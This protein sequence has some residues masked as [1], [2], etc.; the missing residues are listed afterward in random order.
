MSASDSSPSATIPPSAQLDSSILHVLM[1]TIPDKI[2]FKDLQS[3]IVRNNIAHAKS[4]GV[5]SPADCIGKTD[6]DFFSRQHADEALRDEQQILR[7]NQPMIGKVE[8]NT[9]LDGSF[10]WVSTTK[11]PWRDESGKLIGTFGLTRDITA[12]K[13]AEDK[14]NEERTLLRT[15]IDHLPSRIFVKDVDGRYVLNN[16]SHLA[17]LGAADQSAVT[18]RLPTDFYG[19]KRA[20]QAIEDDRKV[21]AGGPPV[22]D[23]EKSD[24]AE[25]KKS[26]WALTTK[27]PLKD[28]A[29]TITGI[30]GISHD[31][32]E[33][34]RTEQELQRRTA[35]METD[36][37][38]ACQ[39]QEAFFPREY[40]VF[41]RGV[42]P[43]A[44][45][46]Q[47]AHRYLPAATLGGDFFD[48][49]QLSDSQCGVLICD[50]MGHGVRAGLLT[51]LIRGL[52]EEFAPRVSEPA[53]V[54]AEINRGLLPIIR[55]TGQ[56][57]FATAFYGI[58]DTE[59]A[60]LHYANGGHPPPLIA[61]AGNSEVVALGWESPEPAAGLMEGFAYSSRKV[62][63]NSGDTLLAYTDGFM[64][65][66]NAAGEM[67]GKAR[68]SRFLNSHTA[69]TG[70]QIIAKLVDEIVVFAGRKDFDDDLCA[71]VIKST[72]QTCA[73]QPAYTYQI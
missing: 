2:Y 53:L 42:P 62:P 67:F 7:T 58:I 73:L 37:Q 38:M 68:L 3:R 51:A 57:V 21:L 29:G 19:G 43:E 23:E 72:G 61:H 44:S 46:L 6:Y 27:I 41:P 47:F 63:F 59:S 15:I 31:I 11:L 64:E 71:V 40:P 22:I 39:I 14:L 18:G 12:T 66:S 5:D 70:E 48:I 69:L 56:P 25:G 65:A 20:T 9:M 24:F 55:Q 28:P 4:L 60:T 35:E 10:T 13:L 1:D 16:R 45:Q 30:V 50:V 34:K 54:L 17:A 52:V 49:F 26:R 33:R 32:T 36:V 8:K